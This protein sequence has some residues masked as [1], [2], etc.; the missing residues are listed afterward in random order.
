MSLK[1]RDSIFGHLQ[2][3][4]KLTLFLQ[5]NLGSNVKIAASRKLSYKYIYDSKKRNGNKIDKLY[6]YIHIYLYI[7][8][9][10]PS[11]LLYC[12]GSALYTCT[13]PPVRQLY[14]CTVQCMLCPAKRTYFHHLETKLKVL[15]VHTKKKM[16]KEDRGEY[17][18]G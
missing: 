12:S 16:F 18:V 4:K 10:A 9:K 2:D 8:I 1:K 11:Y 15:R 5:L 14:E 17:G 3:E 6:I 7:Y 13:G